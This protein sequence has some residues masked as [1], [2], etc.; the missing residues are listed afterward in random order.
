MKYREVRKILEQNGF[1]QEKR[2]AGSHRQYSAVINGKKRKVTL[3]Y[4]QGGEDVKQGVLSSIVRQ[5]G[6]DKKLFR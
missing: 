4:N 2:T 3:A 6:L 5:S 1:V